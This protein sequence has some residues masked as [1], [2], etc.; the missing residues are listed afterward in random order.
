MTQSEAPGGA[1]IMRGSPSDAFALA[2]QLG[3]DGVELHVHH[4]SQINRDEV[5][6]LVEKYGL[7]IPTL[8]TGMAATQ[9]GLTFSD[10]D[11]GVRRRAMTRIKEHIALAAHLDS[12]VTIGSINGRLGNDPQKRPIHREAALDCLKECSKAAAE[13]GVT[14]LLE[15][16]NRYEC[17]YLNTVEEGIRVIREVDVPNLKLLADTFHMNIEEANIT[18]SFRKAGKAL[19]HV[20]LADSNRQAPGYGH[21]DVHN[22]LRVLREMEYRGYLSF[23]ILPLPTFR[24]AAEDAIRT[25]KKVL[26]KL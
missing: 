2:S 20:H 7:G 18:A 17:D 21:L 26:S 14:I 5:K 15:P 24:Q 12:A 10:P 13:A 22:V 25:V 1:I 16:L 6:K 23:E 11:P 8:G 9:E 19:G 3:Y 4:P